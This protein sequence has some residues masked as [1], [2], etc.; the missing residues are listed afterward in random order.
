ML[1]NLGSK[2]NS[3]KHNVRHS[4]LDFFGDITKKAPWRKRCGLL[5]PSC[6]SQH[7]RTFSKIP[8]PK[9]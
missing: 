1:E 8:K 6:F 5:S 9:R 7:I 4:L 2:R 3:W